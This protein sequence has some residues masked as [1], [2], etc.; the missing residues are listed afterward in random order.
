MIKCPACNGE[1]GYI[2]QCFLCQGRGCTTKLRTVIYHKVSKYFNDP[3]K[4]H[5]WFETSNPM[6]GDVSPREMLQL[7]RDEKLFKFI[8]TAEMLNE[9]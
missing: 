4:T 5:L 6:L 3:S 1:G 2:K 7:G 9:V 8:R